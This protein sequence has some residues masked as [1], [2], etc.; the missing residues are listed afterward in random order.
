MQV[1]SLANTSLLHTNYKLNGIF[2]HWFKVFSPK[3][4][5][6][7]VF[8]GPSFTNLKEKPGKVNRVSNPAILLIIIKIFI[9][10]VMTRLSKLDEISNNFF[11]NI[12]VKYQDIAQFEISG[13]LNKTLKQQNTTGRFSSVNVLS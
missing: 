10:S 8:S 7:K 12:T 11:L 13:F 6:T 3:G 2:S 4:P 9:N 5:H 1:I